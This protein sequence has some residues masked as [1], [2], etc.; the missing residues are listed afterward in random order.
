MQFFIKLNT[1]SAL[2]AIALFIAIELIVNVSHIS[3]LTG[4]EWDNVYIV[5]AIINVIG[6]LL[7]TIFFIFLTKKWTIGSKYS[8]LSLLLWAPYFI[9]FFSFF[10]VVFPINEGVTL[11]PRFSLLIYGSVILY[12]IYI[13]FINLYASPLRTDNEE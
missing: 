1:L 6:L 13:L 2:N 11:F 12:P 9:L 7:S 3:N 8:Y 5:I 10:P 4:W